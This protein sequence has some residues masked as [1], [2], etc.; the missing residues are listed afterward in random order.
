M[1]GH[2]TPVGF[3]NGIITRVDWPNRNLSL[4]IDCTA[5]SD[6]RGGCA[7]FGL[8]PNILQSNGT[9]YQASIVSK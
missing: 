9:K 7:N 6:Q 5:P 3:M 4:Y 8:I 1:P 2:V